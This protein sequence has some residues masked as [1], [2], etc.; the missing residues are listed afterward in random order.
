MNLR[1]YKPHPELQH[2]VSRIMLS[3]FQLDRSYPR[4]TSPFPPQPEHS[5]YFYPYD[6]VISRNYANGCTSETPQSILVGPQL[7]RVDVTL[8]YNMLV[9]LVGF[10]PGG[11]HRLLRIPMNEILNIPLD[12]RLILGS[13][14]ETI[15]A[16]LAEAPSFDKMVDII[17][18]YLLKKV[19]KLKRT[20]PVEYVLMQM[21]QQNNMVTVDQLAKEACVSTRQLERQFAER[22]GMP[23]KMFARLVRFSKAWIMREKNPAISWTKIAYACRYADQTHMIRDFKEF[24]GVTPNVLQSDLERSTLR[25]QAL[26]FH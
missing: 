10:Q 14:I 17:Q 2:F 18:L 6:K 15:T 11:L 8:G 20:L 4:L 7:S 13:E 12:A 16:Q 19:G 3:S 26:T 25:L 22:T 24:A 23:P 1:F 9:I 5:L 21:L